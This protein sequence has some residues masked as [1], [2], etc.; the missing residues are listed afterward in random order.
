MKSHAGRI[1]GLHASLFSHREAMFRV[2]ILPRYIL[3]EFGETFAL[4]ALVVIIVL[5]ISFGFM[6]VMSKKGLDFA[7]VFSIFPLLIGK[8][9]PYALPFAVVCA[10]T[11]TYGRL[12]GDNEIAAMRANGI[13]LNFIIMPTLALALAASGLT[14]IINDRLSPTLRHQT[15]C[16]QEEILKNL[17]RH[18]ASLGQPTMTMESGDRHIHLY[19]DRIEG[20][21]LKGVVIFLSENRRL[22]QTVVANSGRLKFN[23]ELK[24]LTLEIREGSIKNIDIKHPARI[25]IVPA[26]LLGDKPTEFP[27]VLE[28]LGELD[29]SD[30]ELYSNS[31]LSKKLENNE[32][33]GKE[34]KEAELVMYGRLAS[35]M[36]P[37]FLTFLVVPLSISI[38]RGHMVTAF[39][40]G[41]LVVIGY[42][43]LLLVGSKFIG[44]RLNV[45]AF[46][47]MWLPNI[48][49]SVCGGILLV[50]VI[51]K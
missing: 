10:C 35:S 38:K 18:F 41:M 51:N 30:P 46:W 43:V 19:V 49:L 44:T 11:L 33:E 4:A 25:N 5:F 47:A 12:S 34:K 16:I 36:S 22:Y 9:L 27:I 29:I 32:Y 15:R 24:Q 14:F 1:R 6:E 23:P 42:L 39:L 48:I 8:V 3:R 26:R 17:V 7:N 21:E 28:N 45:P 37:F 13:H 50:R 20:D 31:E 40:V 2:R